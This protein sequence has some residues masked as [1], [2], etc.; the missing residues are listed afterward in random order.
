[1]AYKSLRKYTGDGVTTDFL[2]DVPYIKQADVSA[3]VQG[4]AEAITWVDSTHV[5]FNPAPSDFFAIT[6]SR[7]TNVD[8][9]TFL[10]PDLTYLKSTNLDGDFTQQLYLH[11][12]QQDAF[13]ESVDLALLVDGS[14]NMLDDLKIGDGAVQGDLILRHDGVTAYDPAV[15]MTSN[16]KEVLVTL[17]TD[18]SQGGYFIN[19][20]HPGG[21]LNDGS[22]LSLRAG[23]LSLT[24]GDGQDSVPNQNY[25]LIRKDWLEG[26]T[27]SKAAAEATLG[28]PTSNG[29][30]L[31]SQ[32][33]GTR[34]WVPL[35]GGG[36]FLADG[37][38]DMTGTLTISNTAPK[39]E[40]FE[41]DV[42]SNH[43]RWDMVASAQ[44]LS[45]RAINDAGGS[46]GNAL[47]ISRNGT[48]ITAVDITNPISTS[49]QGLGTTALTRKEYVDDNFEAILGNP[50]SDGQ[51]LS[52]TVAGVRSW[53]DPPA[54]GLN[55]ISIDIGTW[56]MTGGGSKVVAHGLTFS[57]I[58]GVTVEVYNDFQT[59]LTSFPSYLPSGTTLERVSKDST[60]ITLHA[61]TNGEFDWADYDSTA[62]NRGFIVISYVD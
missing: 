61:A 44:G 48:N 25:H 8:A 35:L 59:G 16:S 45:L 33:D 15:V 23:N 28:N 27:Y 2:F 39:I 20:F 21:S 38:V 29:L 55:T 43:G 31:V 42:A 5:R 54:S 58:R 34:S 6:I 10:F 47:T 49:A 19:Q 17:Q 56:N 9:A 3:T 22:I 18:S 30:A 37:T 7:Q 40:W 14:R 62:I 24:H 52:S 51:V 57:K 32:T 26:Y 4:E 41:N 13:S 12:E 53:I 1:M 46:S 11:Q 60:N 50:A 36:D